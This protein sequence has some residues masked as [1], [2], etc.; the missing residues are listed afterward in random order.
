MKHVL[1]LYKIMLHH[2]GYMISGLFFMFGFAFLSGASLTM[3]IPLFDYV[4]A[5]RTTGSVYNKLSEFFDALS[6]FLSRTGGI[7]GL[8]DEAMRT[9]LVNALKDVMSMTDPWLLLMVICVTFFTLVFI[10]NLF[11]FFNNVIFATLRGKTIYEIRNDIFRKYL[12]QSLKFFNVNKAGDSLV[13]MVNDVN[14]VSE[15]FIGQMFNLLRDAFLLFVYAGIAISLN[16]KFFFL[17]LIVLPIFS[18]LVGLLGKKIKKYAVRIQNKFSDMF[19]NI[20]EVL[21]NMKIVMAFSRENY[22]LEK[23]KK[24]NWK[25]FLFWRKS[26]VY[27]SINTPLG[28]LHGTFTGILVILVGGRLVLSPESGFTSGEFLMFLFAIFS[29]LH[30]MKTLTKAY[31]DIKRAQ[32]SLERIFFILNRKEEIRNVENPIHKKTFDKRIDLRNVNFG[33]NDG[34]DVLKNINLGINKGEKVAFVGSSGAGKTTLV[35]LLPRMYDINSG[36]IFIDGVNI[37]Q[38]DL[39]NLRIL[40][41]TVTQDSILF[42]DTIAN[43]IRYG[44]LEEIPDEVKED[45]RKIK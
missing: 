24:I 2:W 5:P 29:M 42:S 12:Q 30:P 36:E 17:S 6:S 22:E 18:L 8:R 40:F 19:S 31:T 38:I 34:I 33:Y 25:Y 45:D 15:M 1:K 37:K 43:N 14:I 27:S 39:K 35:N 7:S 4:F 28:E 11:F 20:E 32:V 10:K 9:S 16:A 23:F 26:I 21:N 41:G 3:V 44:T 13:R